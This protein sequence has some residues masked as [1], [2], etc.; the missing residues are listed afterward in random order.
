MTQF[1][2]IRDGIALM[3]EGIHTGTHGGYRWLTSTEHYSGTILQRCPEV[4]LQRYVAVTS[5]DG[6]VMHITDAQRASGWELRR[7]IGYSPKLDNV[8][9]IPYQLDGP[10]APGYDEFYVFEARRDL[11]ERLQGNIFVEQFAPTPG[12]TAV[13]VSWGAFVLHRPDRGVQILI[14]LFWPQLERL[15]PE[16]YIADGM[17]CLTFISRDKE[18]FDLVRSRLT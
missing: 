2:T 13:F 18:L 8:A 12:R 5:V 15:N 7:G 16:S 3:D 1:V 4:F 6:G 11:G 9:D 14:D 17:E 10:D